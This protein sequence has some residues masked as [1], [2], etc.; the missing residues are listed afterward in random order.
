MAM[1]HEHHEHHG[2]KESQI[3]STSTKKKDGLFI[4]HG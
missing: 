2:Q 4:F 1:K 3:N